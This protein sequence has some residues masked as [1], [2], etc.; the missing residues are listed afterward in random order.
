MI[1]TRAIPRKLIMGISHSNTRER[2]QDL[3]PQDLAPSKSIAMAHLAEGEH[4]F[5][6]GRAEKKVTRAWH[7][8]QPLTEALEIPPQSCSRCR[9]HSQSKTS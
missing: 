9:N 2:G 3:T 6:A 8:Q 5:E 7:Q 1:T 4:R